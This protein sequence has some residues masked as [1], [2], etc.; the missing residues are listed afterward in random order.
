MKTKVENP[1]NYE[2]I[3]SVFDVKG[4]P[5]VFTYGDTIYNPGGGRIPDHL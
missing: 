4:K 1:P 5:L 3:A 2:K